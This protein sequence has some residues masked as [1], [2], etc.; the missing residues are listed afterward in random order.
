MTTTTISLSV[1]ISNYDSRTS[2]NISV[3]LS[4]TLPNSC[5]GAAGDFST[6]RYTPN[7]EYNIVNLNGGS[8]Y[9]I[10]VTISNVAGNVTS[11]RITVTTITVA[12]GKFSFM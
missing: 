2:Y 5:S 9:D 11:D 12:R 6:E 4:E 1:S 8:D 10:V 7:K 3:A